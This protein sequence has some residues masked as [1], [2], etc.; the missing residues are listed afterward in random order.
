MLILTGIKNSNCKIFDTDDNSNDMIP[1]SV[2]SE[3]IKEGKGKIYGLG[4]LNKPHSK[5][6]VP[7]Y[8]YGIYYSKSDAQNAAA[9]HYMRKYGISRAEARKRAGLA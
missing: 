6:S 4:S 1:L 5:D 8:D 9:M 2:V 7:L 3:F